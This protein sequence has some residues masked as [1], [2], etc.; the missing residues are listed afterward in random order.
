MRDDAVLV[1][2]ARGSLIDTSALVEVLREGGLSRAALDVTDPEPLPDGHP[3]WD[4]PRATITPHS[5]NPGNAQ[6]AR[7]CN[8]VTENVRRFAAGETL[9]GVVDLEAG[10]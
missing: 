1:N 5:A 4:E 10:Y 3:L 2:I 7:L 9:H 8:L 6:V